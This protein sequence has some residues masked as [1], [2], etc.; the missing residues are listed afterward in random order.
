MSRVKQAQDR[1]YNDADM[2]GMAKL[3]GRLRSGVT[4]PRRWSMY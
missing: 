2:L 1:Y 3:L 4:F